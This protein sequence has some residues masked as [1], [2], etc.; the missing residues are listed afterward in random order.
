[1]SQGLVVVPILDG[2]T[3]Q[4]F[5]MLTASD[6]ILILREVCLPKDNSIMEL[7]FIIYSIWSLVEIIFVVLF[8]T[9]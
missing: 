4:L 1:M 7:P 9:S 5:G 2:C 8:C 3:G 6:F